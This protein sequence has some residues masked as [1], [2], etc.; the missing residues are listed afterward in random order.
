LLRLSEQYLIR[1]EARTQLGQYTDAAADLNVV[2][3]RA[4]LL[5]TTA[6]DKATLT[7]AIEKECRTEFFCEWGHRWLDLKRWPGI[8]NA[9][10]TRADEVLSVVKGA[11]WQSTDAFYPIPQTARNVNSTLTQNPGYSN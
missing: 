3:T 4:G 9:S 8:N 5:N 10:L 1:A 2:R 7:A 11:Q 6:T